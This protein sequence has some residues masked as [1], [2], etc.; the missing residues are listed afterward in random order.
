MP[1]CAF[2][3]FLSVFGEDLLRIPL[4]SECSYSHSAF[5]K[6]T[7]IPSVSCDLGVLVRERCTECFGIVQSVSGNVSDGSECDLLQ[8]CADDFSAEDLHGDEDEDSQPGL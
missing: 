3:T 6:C 7:V 5:D 4:K 1:F 2:S 8:F